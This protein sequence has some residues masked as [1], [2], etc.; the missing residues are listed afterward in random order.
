MRTAYLSRRARG[1]GDFNDPDSE[2][3]VKSRERGGRELMPELGYRPVNRYLPPR[4]KQAVPAPADDER[5]DTTQLPAALRW[6]D[7]ILSR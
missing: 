7:R 4:R 5:L 3:S 1:F 2:V 6:L